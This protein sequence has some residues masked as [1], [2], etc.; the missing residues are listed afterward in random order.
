[1]SIEQLDVNNQRI[2]PD[3]EPTEQRWR[4]LSLERYEKGRWRRPELTRG[5]VEAIPTFDHKSEL[6]R[7]IIKLEP[8]D[9]P[10]LFALRPIV[11]L[12][13][14]DQR[15][16]PMLNDIDGSLFRS[17]S[18]PVAVEYRIDSSRNQDRAQKGE[19]YPDSAYLTNLLQVPDE[20]REVL[21]PIAEQVVGTLDPE[22]ARGRAEALANFLRGPKSEFRYTLAIEAVD[23]KL[24]PVVDFVVNRKEGHCEFFASA[25]TLM[26]RTIG[27]PARMINGFKGGDYNSM[28][29][30]TTV[31]QKHAHS[32][33]EVL[34]EPNRVDL[35][36][37]AFWLTLDPTPAD[38][39][40]ASVAQVGGM[41]GNFREVTD[42]VRFV[43]VFYIVGFN[44]DRQDLERPEGLARLPEPGQLLLVPR[45]CR[46]LHRVAARRRTGAAGGGPDP[47]SLAV[48]ARS[49]QHARFA[50]H[51]QRLPPALAAPPRPTRDEPTCH[52]NPSR[53]RPPGGHAP[54]GARDRLS[55]GRRRAAAR[56]G[57]VLPNPL[58]RPRPE[59]GGPQP[60]RRS[61][62]RPRSLAQTGR[63]L[64]DRP[65]HIRQGVRRSHP[66][67]TGASMLASRSRLARQSS[68]LASAV[69]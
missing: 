46:H 6:I 59:R 17:D 5:A 8:T 54:G 40:N 11:D 29:G 60:P 16:Q 44:A 3:N 48:D 64:T 63:L 14:H 33:V 49:A 27:I 23:P 25:L 55:G 24:D 53:V 15:F 52:R 58:W 10:V 20:V 7:Q 67:A 56:R 30:L 42:F 2:N 47:P 51:R 68:T 32:W 57:C 22:D 26:A 9:S 62:R 66:S 69:P 43:W 37:R 18:R 38:Q 61:A 19:Q 13:E 21:R 12:E 36:D 39:R 31:R 34:V 4:G 45:L 35:P 28:A 50:E 41:M 1:M 65:A